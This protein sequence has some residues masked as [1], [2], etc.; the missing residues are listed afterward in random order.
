[1][2]YF[3]INDEKII[4]PDDLVEDLKFFSHQSNF[5]ENVDG[6]YHAHFGPEITLR[7]II[8]WKHP[9]FLLSLEVEQLK[10]LA[11]FE[12]FYCSVLHPVF[13]IIEKIN[14][15][16]SSINKWGHVQRISYRWR[17][18]PK[19]IKR[20]LYR[21]FGV[22]KTEEE[23]Y[24]R[25]KDVEKWFSRKGWVLPP[26]EELQNYLNFVNAEFE[27]GSTLRTIEFCSGSTAKTFFLRNEVSMGKYR[28]PCIHFR[29]FRS[30]CG[31]LI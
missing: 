24:V 31:Q 25:C 9:R 5:K 12:D 11:S 26:T 7:Y 8:C 19:T 14:E 28:N 1:M 18:F 20:P 21:K 15:E 29:L 17:P 4:I 22:R 13:D 3:L 6:V 2:K 30:L 27:L 23:C 16:S 10:E